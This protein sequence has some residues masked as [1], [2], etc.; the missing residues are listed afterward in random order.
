MKHFEGWDIYDTTTDV[1]IAAQAE[2]NWT[3]GSHSFSEINIKPGRYAGYSAQFVSNVGATGDPSLTKSITTGASDQVYIFLNYKFPNIEFAEADTSY[4]F[5]KVKDSGTIPI[6]NVVE[7]RIQ[8]NGALGVWYN[9]LANLSAS[10]IYSLPANTNWH[11]LLWQIKKGTSQVCKIYLDGVEILSTTESVTTVDEFTIGGVDVTATKSP[12]IDDL[13]MN[14]DAGSGFTGRPDPSSRVTRIAPNSDTATENWSLS[15][16]ADSYSLI[17][18]LP[19]NGDTNY[20]YTS[21]QP[22]DTVCGFASASPAAG[23]GVVSVRLSGWWRNTSG[24]ESLDLIYLANDG[25]LAEVGSETQANTSY[26]QKTEYFLDTH[27]RTGSSWS[28]STLDGTNWGVRSKEGA[29]G[30]V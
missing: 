5:I 30:G 22:Q 13:F 6:P 21:S 19:H 28:T 26:T 14:T 15:S 27:P 16:G 18:D 7:L 23:L 4:I 9:K 11:S 29:G 10:Q 20:I 12:Y 24:T 1:D 25:T 2:E 3:S 8:Q 17:N